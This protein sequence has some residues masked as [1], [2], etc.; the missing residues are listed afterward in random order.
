M[1]TM[2]LSV[3]LAFILTSLLLAACVQESSD[4]ATDSTASI[5]E[6]ALSNAL[7]PEAD[8][9]R[10]AA[11]KPAEVLE[12]IGIQE[13]M[14]VLDMF[15]GGGWYAEII[16]HVVGEDGTVIAHTNSAYKNF[17]GEALEERFGT[18]RVPQVEILLAE[19][20]HLE[21]EAD[22]F[23]AVIVALSFHDIYHVD[24][25]GSWE[26][27][28]GPAFLA[29]LRKGVRPGGVVAVIDHYAASGAPA[30]VGD[31]LHRIDAELVI[32]TME[33][34]GFEWEAQSNILRNPNDD[35]FKSVFNP[36]MRGKTDR[37]VMRF[38]NPE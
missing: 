8:K 19:N 33:A 1:T 24:A 2:K 28:D 34:A 27:I 5:Y 11:R 21:L 26:L 38:G 16:A 12:F 35:L 25:E 10:D 3:A 29:E 4:T 23:D 20:N 30:N 9:T 37:F 13:G 7:R 15:S 14:R 36:A 18:G 31:T 17:L 22:T 6:A 32:T